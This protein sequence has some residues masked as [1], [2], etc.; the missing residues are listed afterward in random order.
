MK[1]AF[2]QYVND[3][4]EDKVKPVSYYLKLEKQQ[5]I[6]AFTSANTIDQQGTLDAEQYYNETFNK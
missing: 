3:M 6:N 5:I 4:L 1:T 2:K